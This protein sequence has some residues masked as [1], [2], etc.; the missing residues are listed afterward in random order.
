MRNILIDTS[1]LIAIGNKNDSYHH[2]TVRV[3][4]KLLKSKRYFLTT[5]GVILELFN[6]F[7]TI[8]QKPIAIRLFNL[9]HTSKYW[10]C[11]PVD[12]LINKGIVRFQERSD[13][14]WSLVDCIGMRVAENM[15]ITDI[16]TTDHHFIQAGFNI[17]IK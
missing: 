5:N 6:T 9:I 7:S 15:G 10:D 13:K 2:Q 11:I 3:H 16:F 14:N 1:A 17:L 4:K 8:K 12:G